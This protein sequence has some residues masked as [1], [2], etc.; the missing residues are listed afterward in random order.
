VTFQ[1]PWD[2]QGELLPLREVVV[3]TSDVLVI[4]SNVVVYSTG[5]SFDTDIRKSDGTLGRKVLGALAGPPHSTEADAFH[6]T[7]HIDGR[8]TASTR[9]GHGS[10]N[11]G[12]YFSRTGGQG[13]DHHWEQGW[14]LSPIP[15][16]T[17]LRLDIEW[18]EAAGAVV[19]SGETLAA[20]AHQSRKWTLAP[21]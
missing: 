10:S 4:V 5:V 11:Q 7:V 12:S 19:I 20:A 2:E 21:T 15:Q 14:W 13:G 9:D 3:E 6:V 1:P 16:G 18:G 8:V 17:T